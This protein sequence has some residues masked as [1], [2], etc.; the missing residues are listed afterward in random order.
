[1]RHIWISFFLLPLLLV[2]LPL[3]G[4]IIKGVDLAPYLE[5][6][7]LTRY[8]PHAP[9]S[10]PVFILLALLPTSVLS[11]LIRRYVQVSGP[12]VT[13]TFQKHSLPWWGYG[14]FMLTGISWFLAW[15][16]F[17]W[18]EPMQAYTFFPLWLG[19]IVCMNS[20]THMLKGRC[21]LMNRPRF[22][23]ALFPLSSIFWW[24]F[25]YLNRFV[26]NWH[27]LGVENLS[28]TEY[29]FH[30]SLCFS[31]VLPAVQSTEEFLASFPRLAAPLK[32]WQPLISQK[33]QLW[34]WL[35]LILAVPSLAGIS[36]YPDYLFPMLWL[37]PLLII[38]GVQTVCR[39]DTIFRDLPRGDW[40][41]LWLPALAA[42]TCGFF[43]EMWNL[44]S[45]AHWEYSV[46]FVQRFHIFEMPV[47]G[48]GGYLPFGLECMVVSR[49]L[50][51]ILGTDVYG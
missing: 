2:M 26:Q 34:G 38:V 18:F 1:M 8:L 14:G 23:L 44:K 29:I 30:A 48:Y 49:M 41:A 42:L 35:I 51:R 3:A 27:Y 15:N 9:F 43:W 46:P 40:R 25:E 13:A 4:P 39:E 33:P 7:P 32:N 5:F 28:A 17:H 22:F 16:R 31:T 19:Y 45:L 36:I 24:F 21:L 11:I 6:P 47:L 12:G 50:D 10:W 37:A 20:L